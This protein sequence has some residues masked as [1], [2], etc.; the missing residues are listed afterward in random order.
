MKSVLLGLVVM[1]IPLLGGCVNIGL[2]LNIDQSV[3]QTLPKDIAVNYLTDINTKYPAN[4]GSCKFSED[5]WRGPNGGEFAYNS[6]FM[7]YES[8]MLS[9]SYYLVIKLKTEKN[10]ATDW[11]YIV[12]MKS[13]PQAHRKL[14]IDLYSK[15]VSKVSTALK[16]LGVNVETKK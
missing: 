1:A 15:T 9:W 8:T 5:F 12:D 16:S 3:T 13:S 6:S 7:T 2:D 4:D 14:T 10:A 11:C